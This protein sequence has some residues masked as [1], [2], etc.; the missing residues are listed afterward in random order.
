LVGRAIGTLA[1]VLDFHHCYVAGSVALG[2][3]DDFFAIANSSAREMAT[4]AYAHDL[5]VQPSGW[6]SDGPI[7]GA[8]SVAWRV[9]S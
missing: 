4:I 6:G 3:G 5:V 2:F 1:A 7:L 9:A 8:A